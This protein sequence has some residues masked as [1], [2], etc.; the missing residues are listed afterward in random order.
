VLWRL[1]SRP[2]VDQSKRPLVMDTGA[3]AEAIRAHRVVEIAYR[4]DRGAGTRV[5]HP[6]ALY[7]TT[8]GGLCV[9]ALQ[10]SGV[11]RSG[12]LPAWRQFRLM[13]IGEIRVL[14]AHFDVAPDFD[15][16]SGKYRSGLIARV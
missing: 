10:V 14:G 5:V 11:S 7:R 9:D 8:A 16:A 4:C 1:P 15:P 6:H 2:A 3:L 13:D 12:R